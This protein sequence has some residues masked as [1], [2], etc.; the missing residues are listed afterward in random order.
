[1][2]RVFARDDPLKTVAWGFIAVQLFKNGAQLPRAPCTPG[3]I[4]KLDTLDRLFY[5]SCGG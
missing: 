3:G 4:E 5:G 1:M 2:A